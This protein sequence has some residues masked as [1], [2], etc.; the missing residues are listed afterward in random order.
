MH[1]IDNSLGASL[2]DI[3]L[4]HRSSSMTKGAIIMIRSVTEEDGVSC[5]TFIPAVDIVGRETG[6]EVFL[7][8]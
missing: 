4:R 6:L 3:E 8:R 5:Y 2:A 1:G 7:H